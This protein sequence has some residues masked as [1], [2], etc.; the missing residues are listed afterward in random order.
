VD[1]DVLFGARRWMMSALS[2]N[3]LILAAPC[4]LAGI[5][6]MMAMVGAVPVRSSIRSSCS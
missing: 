1:G 6:L 4:A 3:L 2:T 5:V